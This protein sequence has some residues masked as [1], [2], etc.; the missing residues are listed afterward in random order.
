[1][2]DGATRGAK[3]PAHEFALLRSR[4]SPYTPADVLGLLKL[5]SFLLASNWDSELARLAV[6]ESDGVEA[7]MAI[8]P[9]I[10][11]PATSIGLDDVPDG[12][13]LSLLRADLQHFVAYTGHGGA[14]NNWVLAP[15]RTLWGRPIMANDPHL[16]PDLP[17]HW[18]LAHIA[19]PEWRVA[20][21]ALAGAP[22]IIVGH[23]GRVAWG[24]TAGLIDNTDLFLEEIGE[25]GVSVRRGDT[26]LPCKSEGE[27]IEVRGGKSVSMRYLESDLGPILPPVQAGGRAVSIRATWLDPLPVKGFLGA[28]RAQS[29]EELRQLFREWPSLP[30]N[31]VYADRDGSIGWQ[32]VGRAPIRKSGYGLFPLNASDLE[33]GWKEEPVPFEEMPHVANPPDGVVVTANSSP[34]E[35]DG[36]YLGSD[37][38]EPYRKRRILEALSAKKKWSLEENARLQLDVVSLV[39]REIGPSLLGLETA[40]PDAAL[41]LEIL[42]DWDGSVTADSPAAAIFESFLVMMHRRAINRKVKD[43]LGP[44]LGQ[45]S[46]PLASVTSFGGRMA[47]RRRKLDQGEAFGVV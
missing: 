37:W 23:N 42:G 8:D 47:G 22:G 34:H 4:P 27:T 24:V 13:A 40:D 33:V 28:H 21:A 10:R 30:L 19:T 5:L 1:M 39:W 31:L 25:D 29:G 20:G 3:R 36:P 11:A 14:S 44:A 26:F 45:G 32:L 41:A 6:A 16:T 17:A 9:L 2:T 43:A 46:V 12:G 7:L 18:Y 38:L 35:G 15:D